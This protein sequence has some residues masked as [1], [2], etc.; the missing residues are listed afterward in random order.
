[1]PKNSRGSD[2]L[3]DNRAGENLARMLQVQFQ[4]QAFRA[5]HL[6]ASWSSPDPLRDRIEFEIGKTEQLIIIGDIPSEERSHPGQELGQGKGFDQI[7]VCSRVQTCNSI[8]NGFSRRQHED[9]RP[10]ADVSNSPGHFEPVHTR[11][12]DIEDYQIGLSGGNGG[13]SF[14]I[15]GCQPNVVVP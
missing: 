6:D 1:M 5:S 13:E 8:V 3:K 7:I 10:V 11:Q 12:K 9:G 2:G 15:I 4:E 14:P